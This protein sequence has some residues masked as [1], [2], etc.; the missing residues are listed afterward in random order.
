M[1]R[2]SHS[3]PTARHDPAGYGADA[4]RAAGVPVELPSQVVRQ[5][6]TFSGQARTPG[7][8]QI[9]LLLLGL[10][11]LLAFGVM[12]YLAAT[13]S[14]L[15][16]DVPVALWLQAH[17]GG[18]TPWFGAITA[19]NGTRQTLAGILLLTLVLIVNP[20]TILF[21]FLASLTGPIYSVVNGMVMRPRPSGQLVQVSE[22]LGGTSFPSGH[23]TF[24]A[25]YAT[26]LVLCLGGRYLHRRGLIVAAAIGAAVVIIFSV[27]RIVTGGH[28]PSDVLGGLL[29]AGGWISTLLAVRV[30]GA[31]VL[32]YL[33]RPE[34]AWQI[35]HPGQP[36][37][38]QARLGLRRRTVYTPAVQTLERFGFIVRAVVWGLMGIFAIA[39]VFSVGRTIDLY[40]AVTLMETNAFRLPI[41][42]LATIGLGGYALWGYVRT[43]ADPLQRGSGANGVM[44][45]MGFL[46]SAISYT[47]LAVFAANVGL[48]G[49]QS[50]GDSASQA[51]F[52]AS[53]VAALEGIGLLYILGV[54]IVAVGLGQLLDAW[55]A[56]F[57]H[58]VLTPDAPHGY[59][60]MTWI[61]LGRTGLFAR[62]VLFL[63][64]GGLILIAAWT[65][66]KWSASFAHVFETALEFPA[67]RVLVVL[68]ALGMVALALHSLGGARWIRMR[69][70]VLVKPAAV[71]KT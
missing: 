1:A 53:V 58:D 41:A 70:P 25:T 2:A 33:G 36:Y 31:P 64:S 5:Q 7:P 42:L 52:T 21:A 8:L 68:V 57:T 69:P 28:W 66:G 62:G 65:G 38:L 4:A 44:A 30:I 43:F 39:A 37:T 59:L 12:A 19:L 18:L 56:P 32:R 9:P 34:D 35:R 15:P 20:R 48:S 54:G 47:L 67:G 50:A 17:L 6:G 22:Q 55:R 10:L 63:T 46:W 29:L 16:F 60:W 71:K 23:A 24:A 13:T 51:L 27:A 49:A 26:L 11:L 61:W 40:G 3:A 14:Y 45:R